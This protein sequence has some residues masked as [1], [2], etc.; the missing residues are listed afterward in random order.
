M[1][2]APNCK[3]HYGQSLRLTRAS[4]QYMYDDTSTE[5]LDCISN[6]AH[7]G[8]CHPHVVSRGQQQMARLVW[9]QGFLCDALSLYLK[10]LT[11]MMPEQLSVCYLVNSGSEANDLALRLARS[12]TRREDV[13]V[14]EGAYHGNVGSVAEISPRLFARSRCSRKEYVHVAPLPDTYRGLYR[15]DEPQPGA[16]Y[17]AHVERLL[18]TAQARGRSVAAF[19]SECI[20]T[21]C[22]M[23]VPPS[24]YFSKVYS[25][26]RSRGGVC[27]MDEVQT[28]L[29]RIG[30]HTWAFESYGVVPDILTLGKTLGN[31]HPM[32][33]V[34]TRRDIA[35][36]MSDYYSTFGGNP[37]S[38]TVGLAVLEV[39]RNEQLMTAATNVGRHLKDGL[40]QLTLKHSCIGCVRGRGLCIGV[41][42]VT[43]R[44][45]RKPDA[46]LAREICLRLKDARIITAT[47]APDDNVLQLTPPMCF[48]MSNARTFVTTLERV[49]NDLASSAPCQS[50]SNGSVSGRSGPETVEELMAGE[51]L[52]AACSSAHGSTQAQADADA[53]EEQELAAKR[54]RVYE[55]VD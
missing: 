48:T 1:S 26:V 5:Y 2:N 40:T 43:N 39:M 42:I 37:V 9:A 30:T 4:K 35:D 32:S 21:S 14:L 15:E 54:R 24:D 22:G 11:D 8:H 27:I 12:Y 55:E 36:C 45:S 13:V 51:P 31:G 52:D 29:G 34:V 16:K 49:L 25:L 3:L 17:A 53:V 18:D 38:C 20:I 19:V 28:A 6:A 41:E 10:E 47:L 46:V 44:E 7:V 33:A 50:G 23:V